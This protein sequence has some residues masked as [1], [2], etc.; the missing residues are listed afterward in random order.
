MF[1]RLG[2]ESTSN[3]ASSRIRRNELDATLIRV[4]MLERERNR[5][6]IRARAR[7][8]KVRLLRSLREERRNFHRV[9]K[10]ERT[11]ERS[12]AVLSSRYIAREVTPFRS[13]RGAEVER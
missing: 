4:Q 3:A 6:G 9:D 10:E 13:T 11:R 8:R 7:G 5:N 2:G 12:S 1:F